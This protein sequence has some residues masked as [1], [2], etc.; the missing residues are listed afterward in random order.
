MVDKLFISDCS[1]T[2]IYREMASQTSAHIEGCLNVFHHNTETGF[3]M[4]T[5][6]LIGHIRENKSTA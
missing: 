4:N 3:F 2:K 5:M 1:G 6:L